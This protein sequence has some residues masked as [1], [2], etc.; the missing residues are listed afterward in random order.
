MKIRLLT[1]LFIASSFSASVEI[2]AQYFLT[3]EISES[4]VFHKLEL[5]GP[6]AIQYLEIDLR[7]KNISVET[8]IANNYLGNGGEGV[9][10]LCDRL[11]Q[12][13]ANIIA[14]VNG[15]FFGGKPHQVLNST[16]LNGEFV[17]GTDRKRSQFGLLFNRKP[18]IEILTFYGKIFPRDTSFIVN[19]LNK[20]SS[21]PNIMFNHYYNRLFKRDSLNNIV[22]LKYLQ[23]PTANDTVY[24][25]I[26]NSSRGYFI[27]TLRS[28][29]YLLANVPRES[30]QKYFHPGDTLKAVLGTLPKI[31][32][33]KM[34]IGGLP[35]LVIDGKAID[36][37]TGVEGLS[38]K[39]FIGKN[40]RTAV[41]FN[42]DSTKLFVVTVDGRQTHYSVG[43]T[44][45][46]LAEF[47]VKLGCYQAVNLD[48][49][50]STT[51]WVNGK[52]ENSPSDKSGERP[53]HN[54][55]IVRKNN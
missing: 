45:T 37:F 46:E 21:K 48:G 26:Q 24:F 5:P 2:N 12:R 27:D 13:G 53:V 16:I 50:G 47:M 23:K 38:S 54:A 7:N 32:D 44:L 14:A 17:K 22:L 40:P 8:A 39:K 6:I 18:I 35:R 1:I 41:G 36:N 42:A 10:E 52:I 15:D 20:K 43:M 34:L 55:L 11:N 19:Y 3:E 9:S 25:V 51:M 31:F 28:G 4:V 33:V 49:G 30:I 29:E